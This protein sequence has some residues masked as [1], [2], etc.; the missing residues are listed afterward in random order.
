MTLKNDEKKASIIDNSDLS[1]V[2]DILEFLEDRD[3]ELAISLLKEFND[4]SKALGQLLLNLDPN[5]GHEE[6][7]IDCD[8]AQSLVDNVIHRIEEA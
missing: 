8:K 4:K 6:W 5:L 1:R 2:M 7:K 3:E